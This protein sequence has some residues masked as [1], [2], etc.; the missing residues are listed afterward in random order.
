MWRVGWTTRF[1]TEVDGEKYY[2]TVLNGSEYFHSTQIHCPSCLRQRQAKGETH[3]WHVVVSATVTRAGRHEILPLDA[4]EVRN[5]DGQQKQDCE[6]TAA[7]RLVKRLR[8]EHRQLAMCIV[9]D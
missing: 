4:E 1:V 2:L 5:T 3:Y 7:K 6:L 8:V 9:G